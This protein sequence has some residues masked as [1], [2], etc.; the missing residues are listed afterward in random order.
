MEIALGRAVE[1]SAGSNYNEI[2]YTPIG[3]TAIMNGQT[4]N[5]AYVPLPGVE[6]SM[7]A[8][9]FLAVV[10]PAQG[11]AANMANYADSVCKMRLIGS[12]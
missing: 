10:A 1:V 5:F 11:E 7:Y 4:V 3:K 9:G 2:L 8:T 12:T 6:S